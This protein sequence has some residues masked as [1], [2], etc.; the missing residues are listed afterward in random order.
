M[1]PMLM[2]VAVR[3]DTIDHR[4]G[5]YQP[6][7]RGLR[8][9]LPLVLVWLVLA[10]FVLLLAPLI[11]LALALAGLNPFRALAAVF[12]VLTGLT[13]TRIQVDAPG[14]TVDIRVL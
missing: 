9:W 4:T 8:L 7:G 1:I 12:G 10:P 6:D 14:A 13:G 2:T 5:R 11:I 3:H